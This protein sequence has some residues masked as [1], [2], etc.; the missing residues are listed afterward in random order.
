MSNQ[1]LGEWY[2]VTVNGKTMNSDIEWIY[3][4][5]ALSRCEIKNKKGEL[6][7]WDIRITQRTKVSSVVETTIYNTIEEYE[8]AQWCKEVDDVVKDIINN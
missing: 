7:G 5:D 6:Y 2:T 3:G 8:K 4:D 1:R